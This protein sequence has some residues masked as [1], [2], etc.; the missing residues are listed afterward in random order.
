MIAVVS[1]IV[2]LFIARYLGSLRTVVLVQFGL[3]LLG[4]AALIVTAPSHGSTRSQG[5]LLSVA[6]APLTALVV[7]LGRMWRTRSVAT[8]G[9]AL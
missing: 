4:A 5:V 7:L 3:Y 6:L 9:A 8:V 2:G 1:L